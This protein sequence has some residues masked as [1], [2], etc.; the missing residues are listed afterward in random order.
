METIEDVTFAV[1]L[2]RAGLRPGVIELHTGISAR[3]IRRWWREVHGTSPTPGPLPT[4]GSVLRSAA[5]RRE[6]TDFIA[7]YRT[8]GGN[9]RLDARRILE[10]YRDHQQTWEDPQLTI[11]ETWA[12]VRDAEIGALMA[13]E[14][15][16]C[17][18][19]HYLSMTQR[20]PSRC[21]LC[22]HQTQDTAETM[23]AAES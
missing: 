14:C 16:Y 10:T 17:G 9:L 21:P 20:G 5:R 2:I 6:A 23:D 1:E 12:L 15:P 19:T 7:R 11:T 3:R 8:R 4:G 18:G 13:V 22:R